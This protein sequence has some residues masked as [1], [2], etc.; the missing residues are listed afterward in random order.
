MDIVQSTRPSEGGPPRTNCKRNGSSAVF[1]PIVCRISY[2]KFYMLFRGLKQNALS[3]NH[4]CCNLFQVHL[5]TDWT[6]ILVLNLAMQFSDHC[7]YGM[8]R[9]EGQNAQGAAMLR[10]F[11]RYNHLAKCELR[12][13]NVIVIRYILR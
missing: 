12:S 7:K 2:K 10:H 6:N 1:C 3:K 8:T 11:N 13:S 5:C 9:C 4:F